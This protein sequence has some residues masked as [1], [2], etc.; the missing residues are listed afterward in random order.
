MKFGSY[1]ALGGIHEDIDGQQFLSSGHDVRV[2]ITVYGLLLHGEGTSR[3]VLIASRRRRR[4]RGSVDQQTE[5]AGVEWSTGLA[6][7]SAAEID[8]Q[9]SSRTHDL[10]TGR[11]RG[12]PGSGEELAK[13]ITFLLDHRDERHRMAINARKGF[14]TISTLTI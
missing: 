1:L 6:L 3:H 13:A 8:A 4:C 5:N 14:K 2:L 7:G 10:D 9:R 11:Q 12:T